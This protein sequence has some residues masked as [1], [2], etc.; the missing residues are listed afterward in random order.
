MART[1]SFWLN[2]SRKGKRF[3]QYICKKKEGKHGVLDA[4]YE[5]NIETWW[6]QS[7]QFIN[8]FAWCLKGLLGFQ[9][10]TK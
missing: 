2:E 10:E 3:L 7:S 9:K 1:I 8:V 5:A 4:W 6:S